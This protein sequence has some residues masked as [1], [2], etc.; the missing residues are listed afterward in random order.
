[1]HV[2]ELVPQ[3]AGLQRG[4]VGAIDERAATHRL[5][6]VEVRRLGLVPAGEQAVDD[7]HAAGRGDD[8]R[9][10]AL[11]G[12]DRPVCAGEETPVCRTMGAT[13]TPLAA[14]A[15][16]TPGVTGR[17]ALGISALPGSVA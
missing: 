6:H 15:V 5:E 7:A 12:L 11:A 1:M 13:D 10:P 4:S 2:A 17:P 14:S 16:S 3:V 8:E 9:R